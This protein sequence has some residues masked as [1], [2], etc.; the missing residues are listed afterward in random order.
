MQVVVLAEYRNRKVVAA[1]KELLE[2]AEL[3]ALRGLTFVAKLGP[4][5]HRAGIVGD[6]RHHPE[7]ALI[8]AMRMKERLLV[9]DS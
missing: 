4:G 1:A 7:E 9:A 5:D 3:G 6:Y 8:A 2:L